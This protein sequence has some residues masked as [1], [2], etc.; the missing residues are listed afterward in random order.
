ME[1]CWGLWVSWVICVGFTTSAFA[2]DRALSVDCYLTAADPGCPEVRRAL[3]DSLPGLSLVDGPA[4]VA[5][6]LRELPTP[7]GRRFVADFSGT[8]V[9]ASDHV[10][11]QLVSVV[12][13]TAGSDRITALVIGL[14]QRGLVPFLAMESPG[15]VT[16]G[17]LT[18]VVSGGGE[19]R[20]ERPTRPWYLRPQI[21]ASGFAG[22]VRVVEFGAGLEANYST[23]AW[24]FRLNGTFDYRYLDLRIGDTRLRGGYFA[25]DGSSVLARRL[26]GGWS[27]ALRLGAQRRPQDNLDARVRGGLGLEWVLAPRQQAN[28][29]N[30][31]FRLLYDVVH[32]RFSTENQDSDLTHL[33]QRPGATLFG[34]VHGKRIDFELTASGDL[35][36]DR[37]DLWSVS[38]EAEVAIRL[39][40]GV[41]L[42]LSVGAILRGGAINAPLDSSMLDPVAST[43]GSSFGRLTLYGDVSLSWAIGNSLLAVQDQRW[44]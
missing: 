18:L 43:N 19:A 8:P 44:R 29:T 26:R 6:R 20:T 40:D 27:A 13:T 28:E 15:A 17:A 25:A 31:G 4:P 32:D 38:G 11:F 36:L 22:G 42:A 10:A 2:D 16:D 35:L 33:Y 34:R 21:S 23:D 1:R 7:N 14:L 30:V 5:I 41:Q 12:P 9:D 39:G 3:V 37:P 24:R